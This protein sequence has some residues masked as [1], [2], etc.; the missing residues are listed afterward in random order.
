MKGSVWTRKGVQFFSFWEGGGE[1]FF[2][3]SHVPIM[4]QKNWRWA[5][6]Y[7]PFTKKQS[8]SAPMN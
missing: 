6:Q 1:E 3:F 5:N 7:G 8:V 2:L 4:F